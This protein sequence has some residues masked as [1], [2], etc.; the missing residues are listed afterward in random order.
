[1]SNFKFIDLFCGIGGFHL[2]M[3]NLGGECVFASEIDEHAINVYGQNYG[4]DSACNINE[5]KVDKIPP[6]DVLCAGFPCQSFSKAG[7]RM[8]FKDPTKGT[9]F[10]QIKRVLLA[11]QPKYILLENVRNLLTHDH[12]NTW[13]IIENELDLAG[14][15]AKPIIMSPHQIG[16]PQL[17]ERVYILGVRKDI[18]SNELIFDIPDK[19]NKRKL[20]VYDTGIL[21]KRA[22][23]KYTISAQEERILECWDEFYQGIRIRTIGFP[24]WSSEF[25]ADYLL[26][27]YPKWKAKICLKNRE[28][29]K[30]NKSFIDA[31]LSKWSNLE[32][33]TPTNRKFEWQAG[34]SIS[35][36]WNGIIQ[37]R[38][39]GI[40][41]KKPDTFP[42]LV[43]LVQIPIIGKYKR[44]ITPREAARLQS[45]PE[46]F[47]LDGDDF[48]AYKQLGNAV[49]VNCVE[50]LARQLL[51][52]G[53]SGQEETQKSVRQTSIKAM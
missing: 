23:G 32:E 8:G 11:K 7:K 48:Q 26:D 4:I 17:R 38:P 50:F 35:S 39:S 52:I 12:Y 22:D 45:F 34:S 25:G 16:V 14:Y 36:L 37:F 33:F 40:R 10:F 42:A 19:N 5:V 53:E 2:A 30:D 27:D 51:E 18:F 47:I 9:L 13:R 49:N 44:R 21:S 29:Y 1:M 41:V 15:N 6:F 20:N 31:W 46:S 43:A 3:R 24:V 28:L